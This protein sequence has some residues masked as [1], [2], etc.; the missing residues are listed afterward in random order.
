M[1]WIRPRRLSAGDTV[2]VISPSFPGLPRFKA[3]A[4]RAAGSLRKVGLK[5]VFAPNSSLDTGF[6]AG[7]GAQRAED[8]HWAFAA[9]EVKGIVAAIGGLNCNAVLPHLDFELIRSHPKILVGYSDVTALLASVFTRSKLITFHGP[10][11]LPEWGEFPGPH[12]FTIEAFLKATFSTGPLGLLPTAPAWTDEF[13]EWGTGADS[14]PR[15]MRPNSG[16][17]TLLEGSGTGVLFGGN[18]NTLSALCGTPFLAP[19]EEETV[20]MLELTNASP[21]AFDQMLE[22]LL[23]GGYFLRAKA[24]IVGR[25]HG[26]DKSSGGAPQSTTEA[27]QL[28]IEEVAREKLRSLEIPVISRVDC[29]HTD[30]ML[31]LPLGVRCRV[32]TKSPAIEIL[33]S[34]VLDVGSPQWNRL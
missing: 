17:T 19:P 14:R 21:A 26:Y 20:F 27:M 10:A 32:S 6:S 16:W 11:L 34:A 30:P 24:V 1:N 29:G 25:Y 7:S 28:G 33:E 22:Q 18:A 31:T 23:Q 9:P 13:L 15:V 4:E 8:I 3:R 2:A 5:V 12:P